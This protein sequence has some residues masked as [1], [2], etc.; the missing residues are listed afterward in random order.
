M[1][2]ISAKCHGENLQVYGSAGE[3]R[4]QDGAALSRIRPWRDLRMF[5]G[6]KSTSAMQLNCTAFFLN[7]SNGSKGRCV[8]AMAAPPGGRRT[9]LHLHELMGQGGVRQGGVT[10]WDVEAA[11][12]SCHTGVIHQQQLL[13]VSLMDKRDRRPTQ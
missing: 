9:H 1:M 3:Q 5:P 13:D 6:P 11:V 4:K 10:V 2:G 8:V 7:V 12:V